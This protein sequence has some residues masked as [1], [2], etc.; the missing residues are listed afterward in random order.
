MTPH[1][2]ELLCFGTRPGQ[3]NAALVLRGDRSSVDERQALA[4][5]SSVGACVFLDTDDGVTLDFYYPHARS[6]L[7]LHATLAAARVLLE[8]A[9]G[10]LAVRT[11][12]TGQRLTLHRQADGV[13]VELVPLVPPMVPLPAELPARLV[14]GI[15][16]VAAPAVA[17]VGSPKLLLRVAGPAA[18]HA[19]RPDLAAIQ[20]WGREH[21]INGC[22]VW[23][24]RPD[25]ALE[26]RN[27]N[28]PEGGKEDSAT[29]VAA[30]ALTVLLG[31]SLQVYQGANVGQ[32]CLIRTVWD[33][34]RLLVGG[35]ADYA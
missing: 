9:P 27:F 10:P 3:G 26:G 8:T 13:Y 20:A 33:G 15:D 2:T 29:G 16:L 32:P 18:L 19:L 35:A 31:R 25:G 4:R 6:P 24:E 21:G 22:Y 11:A 14:P 30:G 1:R 7:C 17:S 34:D 28:H 23:C 12:L 5:A